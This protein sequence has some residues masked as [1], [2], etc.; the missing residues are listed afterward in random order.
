[1]Y[2]KVFSKSY[3]E[4]KSVLWSCKRVIFTEST[5]F[6][7]GNACNHV[8]WLVFTKLILASLKVYKR[9][10][11][12][13]A[14]K[15]L[16]SLENRSC[17]SL[18]PLFKVRFIHTKTNTKRNRQTHTQREKRKFNPICRNIH[19]AIIV[20]WFNGVLNRLQQ[21][22]A[23][24][25]KVTIFHFAVMIIKNY[26]IS[27]KGIDCCLINGVNCKNVKNFHLRSDWFMFFSLSQSLYI[28]YSRPSKIYEYIIL[29]MLRL[30]SFFLFTL[31]PPVPSNPTHEH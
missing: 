11:I 15:P 19:D 31:S 24:T 7:K 6:S 17:V 16:A 4:Q 26:T 5:P 2:D 22:H 18:L 13:N 14:I 12:W 28:Y 29:W 8:D 25:L 23:H 20:I 21:T 3:L 9:A 1:M 30:L 27:R 10:K